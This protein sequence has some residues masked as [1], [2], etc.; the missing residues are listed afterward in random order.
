MGATGK[1]VT[2]ESVQVFK[3]LQSV[4]ASSSRVGQGAVSRYR[5][6]RRRRGGRAR[7]RLRGSVG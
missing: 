6:E 1:S 2:A 5:G 3:E 7:G 4:Q